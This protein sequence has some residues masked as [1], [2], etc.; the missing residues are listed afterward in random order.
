[1]FALEDAGCITKKER[2]WEV[3]EASFL[4]WNNAATLSDK[5]GEVLTARRVRLSVSGFNSIFGSYNSY[6]RRR[7]YDTAEYGV[8]EACRFLT[9]RSDSNL[10][11]YSKC[12]NL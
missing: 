7:K 8:T 11:D 4:L 12:N 6:K 10:N 1:M 9:E 2:V 5:L 3:L